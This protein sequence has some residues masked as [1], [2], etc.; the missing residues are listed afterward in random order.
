MYVN[1]SNFQE[2]LKATL[3]KVIIGFQLFHLTTEFNRDIMPFLIQ[4]TFL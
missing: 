1:A 2:V 3:N 4:I